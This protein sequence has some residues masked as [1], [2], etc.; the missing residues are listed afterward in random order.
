[1]MV[2]LYTAQDGRQVVITPAPG[3]APEQA[4]SAV[5]AGISW[6]VADSADVPPEPAPDEPLPILDGFQFRAFLTILGIRAK[7]EEIARDAGGPVLDA[8][9]YGSRFNRNSPFILQSTPA[10]VAVNSALADPAV[11]DAA[12]RQA[13]TIRV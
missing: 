3:V 8:F 4:A 12:W 6:R 13:A 9:E 1:M 2:V 11:I 7:A 5:P 10:F